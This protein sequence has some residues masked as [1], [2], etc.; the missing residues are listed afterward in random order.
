MEAEQAVSGPTPDLGSGRSDNAGSSPA[1]VTR[2]KESSGL[3]KAIAAAMGGPDETDVPLELAKAKADASKGKKPI[4]GDKSGSEDAPPSDK[5]A[6]ANPAEA[7]PEGN[8]P[9]RE[10]P[11]H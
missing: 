5:Q 2:S 1:P 4:A 6:E 7:A 9:V 10:A 3:D 8:A 11:K